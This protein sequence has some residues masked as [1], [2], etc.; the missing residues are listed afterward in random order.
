METFK[1]EHLALWK[2]KIKNGPLKIK[3]S[4]GIRTTADALK[5][6]ETGADRI[7]CSAG[8]KILKGLE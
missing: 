1:I 2:S 8:V 3:A 5:F 7:G 6:L 4:G